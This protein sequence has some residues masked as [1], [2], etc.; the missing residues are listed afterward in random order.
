MREVVVQPQMGSR[1]LLTLACLIVLIAGLRAGES[2]VVP[3]LLSVFLAM[4]GIPLQTWLRQHG[5]PRSLAIV[6]VVLTLVGVLVGVGVI[7][8]GSLN[9]FV[10]ALPE[11]EARLTGLLDSVE[12][13]LAAWGI[14]IS[15]SALD[16]LINPGQILQ[17]ASSLFF[18]VAGIL[19]NFLLVILTMIFILVEAVGFPAKLQAAFGDAGAKVSQLSN[20]MTQVHHYLMIKTTI[21]FVTGLGL[22]LWVWIWGVDFP[23]LWGLLA[24]LLNY[25]PNIGSILAAVPPVLVGLIQPGGSVGLSL[26]VASGYVAVNLVLG[27][28]VEPRVMG[29]RLGLSTLVV[30]VSLVF[31]GW[32]WGAVGM[33]L[34][35]PLTM[36]VKILMQNSDE[37]RWVAIL[38]GKSPDE[39]PSPTPSE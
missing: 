1:V 15:V 12:T 2:V 16:E 30:F 32:V 13:Q 5:M 7:V 24:F 27:N 26:A 9:A 17:L 38:L 3:F 39:L 21:S 28:F 23:I 10:N 35:V 11:Y 6:V 36:V 14:N 37:L 8:G 19:S 4:L 18:G 25:V 20:V 33:L 22:G 31:W 34:S 29:Q